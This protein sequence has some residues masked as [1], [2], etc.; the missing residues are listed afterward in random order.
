MGLKQ[1]LLSNAMARL[2]ETRT[3]TRLARTEAALGWFI[4][5]TE[6]EEFVW[7]TGLT[8]S[9]SRLKSH[10]NYPTRPSHRQ[11]RFNATLNMA[12]FHPSQRSLR[13]R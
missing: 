13:N 1:T 6:D 10:A 2:I 7:K 3:L 11:T 9:L 12:N 4:T 5:S 8:D